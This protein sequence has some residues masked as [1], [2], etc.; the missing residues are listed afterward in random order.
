MADEYLSTD[1][2]AGDTEYIS[3]DPNA[4]LASPAVSSEIAPTEI[5]PSYFQAKAGVMPEEALPPQGAAREVTLGLG[6]VLRGLLPSTPEAIASFATPVVGAVE[7]IAR[8]GQAVEKAIE[9]QP[10]ESVAREQFPEA[11]RYENFGQKPLRQQVA[12]IGGDVA[13]VAMAI[14]IAAGLS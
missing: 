11:Y 12:T 8:A 5:R 9:G 14:P 13:N 2:N 4:G 1:P 10:I 7:N 3:N 6:D